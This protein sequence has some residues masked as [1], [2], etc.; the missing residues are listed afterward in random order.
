M[1]VHKAERG[2]GLAI[3]CTLLDTQEGKKNALPEARRVVAVAAL[4]RE[5]LDW[6][7]FFSLVKLIFRVRAD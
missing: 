2:L 7:I 3:L 4:Q 1:S 5:P 6:S